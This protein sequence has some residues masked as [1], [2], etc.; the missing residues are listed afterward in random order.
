LSS[1]RA[2]KFSLFHLRERYG[3][4]HWFFGR[5]LISEVLAA[6][7][8]PFYRNELRQPRNAGMI[9]LGVGIAGLFFLL[10]L[11]VGLLCCFATA[12]V[13]AAFPAIVFPGILVAE[14]ILWEL[15]HGTMEP[16]L[17]TP[18][19]R[20]EILWSKFAARLRPMWYLSLTVAVGLALGGTCVGL[21]SALA[22][23]T[24]ESSDV[25]LWTVLGLLCGTVGGATC[26]TLL[27]GQAATGG[28][29][30]ILSALTL[31]SRISSYM[32]LMAIAGGI[33]LLESMVIGT[34]IAMAGYALVI[35]LGQSNDG[36]ALLIAALIFS[37]AMVLILL[38]TLLV[39]W[40]LPVQVM[41]SCARRMDAMLLSGF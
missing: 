9:L 41:R 32:L 36:S 2:K 24:L 29:L 12:P 14:S 10:L 34:T 19:S 27:L 28:A 15:D 37:G 25:V 20:E 38:R 1:H 8:S 40:F 3:E 17:L 13:A 21:F 26:G 6:Q 16:L 11:L 33:C 7:R 4:R 30:A 23:E 18:A 31:R 5:G 22:T 35:A 39:N